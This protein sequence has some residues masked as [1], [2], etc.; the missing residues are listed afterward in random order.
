M[1]NAIKNTISFF[2]GIVSGSRFNKNNQLPSVQITIKSTVAN[3]QIQDIPVIQP[4]GFLSRPP[5]DT[6]YVIANSSNGQS[7]NALGVIEG[8]SPSHPI[9][10]LEQE[11][12]QGIKFILAQRLDG[13]KYYI[14]DKTT[15]SATAISGEWVVQILSNIIEDNNREIRNW[16]NIELIPKLAASQI[17]VTPIQPNATLEKDLASIKAGKCLINNQATMPE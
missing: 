15:Y 14:K 1:F 7:P 4:Y 12:S 13:A 3:Y 10:L 9:E 8:V 6:R 17:V 2:V 11:T 5:K 16:I